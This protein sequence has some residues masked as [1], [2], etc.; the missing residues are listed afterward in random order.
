M[1]L[2]R[3]IISLNFCFRKYSRHDQQHELH[4]LQN[5]SH[6]TTLKNSVHN[7]KS[8]VKDPTACTLIHDTYKD[9]YS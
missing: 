2:S 1:K 9:E 6:S 8:P 7:N 4:S 5:S 3:A